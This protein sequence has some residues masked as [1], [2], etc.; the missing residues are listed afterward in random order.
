MSNIFIR[1]IFHESIF[2]I[3]GKNSL[4]Q[5]NYSFLYNS[6]FGF[7]IFLEFQMDL[8]F[9]YTIGFKIK[10]LLVSEVEILKLRDDYHNQSSTTTT[11]SLND[12]VAWAYENGE[13]QFNWKCDFCTVFACIKLATILIRTNT[14]FILALINQPTVSV[15]FPKKK[16]NL[17]HVPK[18][19][20]TVWW[21][22]NR[23]WMKWMTQNWVEVGPNW[24]RWEWSYWWWHRV[25]WTTIT[26][27]S[28]Y[29]HFPHHLWLCRCHKNHHRPFVG[30]DD[31]IV[32]G[33]PRSHSNVQIVLYGAR[34]AL[35]M[36]RDCR[37]RYTCRKNK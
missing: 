23:Q 34:V 33:C 1:N 18:H 5:I 37:S 4:V 35:V 31:N 11:W 26:T 36:G 21:S 28:P 3:A 30:C 22:A 13:L 29:P 17:T 9:F 8:H 6:L 27:T 32:V 7:S 24:M 20:W 25:R 19:W 16:R 10:V 15:N 12:S 14:V 2:S